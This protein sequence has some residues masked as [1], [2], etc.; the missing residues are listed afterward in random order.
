[1]ALI[2]AVRQPSDAPELTGLLDQMVEGL[3]ERDA[4]LVLASAIRG[5]LDEQVRDRII[6]ETRVN[7][8]ALVELPRVLTPAELAGGFGI[9][10]TATVASR[11]EESFYRQFQ[12]LPDDTQRLLLSGRAHRRHDDLAAR[13]RTARDRSRRRSPS[14]GTCRTRRPRP[15]PPS[16]GPFGGLAAV[17]SATGKWCTRPGGGDRSGDR[18]RPPR[19]LTAQA[20]QIARLARD[21]LANPEIG[22]QLFLSPRTA[23]WHLGRFAFGHSTPP[24][25]VERRM[26]QV[27]AAHT[28]GR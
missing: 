15:V 27:G 8:L 1:M 26:N 11:S 21:D 10:D 5:P 9:P 22:A 2:F 16:T 20:A 25:V 14:C 6:A 4:R 13:G 12:S 17:A 3:D 7:P 18:P 23:A 24:T 28:R 19:V